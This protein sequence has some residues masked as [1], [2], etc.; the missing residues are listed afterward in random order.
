MDLMMPVLNGFEATR[1]LKAD[2]QTRS[3]PVLA[4]TGSTT[5]EDYRHA[6]EVGFDAFLAKPVEPNCLVQRLY[7]LLRTPDC[8]DL[9]AEGDLYEVRRSQRRGW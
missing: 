1:R 5:P 8:S 2:V 7:S 4:L 9:S 6:W 3:I